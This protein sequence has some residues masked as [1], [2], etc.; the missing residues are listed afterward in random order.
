[1]P[2]PTHSL[3]R[4]ISTPCGFCDFFLLELRKGSL[5]S[6]VNLMSEFLGICH[7][8]SAHVGWPSVVILALIYLWWG[9]S[10]EDLENQSQFSL[11]FSQKQREAV[12][13]MGFFVFF[14][15]LLIFAFDA[16]SLFV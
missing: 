11:A 13:L 7:V 5:D 10:K 16:K 2:S 15:F 1:M 4:K 14:F 3:D 12:V 6:K 8:R 9:K